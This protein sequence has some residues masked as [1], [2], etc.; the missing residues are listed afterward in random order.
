LAALVTCSLAWV[1]SSLLVKAIS[2][3]D[4][5][6]II[7][8]LALQDLLGFLV[9]GIDNS[10]ARG[11]LLLVISSRRC[12]CVGHGDGGLLDARDEVSVYDFASCVRIQEI[13]VCGLML[14]SEKADL[15]K[16][17]C[18]VFITSFLHFPFHLKSMEAQG[19]KL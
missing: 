13:F 15:L 12:S 18:F 7:H 3:V 19:R 1:K 16:L 5:K 9:H 10:V 2:L 8:V 6:Q 11:G 14:Q 17:L 4:R